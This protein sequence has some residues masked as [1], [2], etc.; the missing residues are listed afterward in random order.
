[1][2]YCELCGAANDVLSLHCHRCGGP[3]QTGVAGVPASV[4][5]AAHQGAGDAGS[6][7]ASEINT[8][9]DLPDW[10]KR[11][12]AQT[13]PQPAGARSQSTLNLPPAEFHVAEVENSGEATA[14]TPQPQPLPPVPTSG[15]ESAVPAWLRD[16]PAGEQSPPT[17]LSAA[18]PQ[19]AQPAVSAPVESRTTVPDADA[20]NT[21]TFIA[22]NDLPDWIRQIAAADAAKAVEEQ[23]LAAEAA[24]KAQVD[25]QNRSVLPGEERGQ[26]TVANPWLSRRDGAGASQ[27]WDAPP[28][29]DQ[30]PS[31][32]EL[33]AAAYQ[34]VTP[35]EAEQ[36]D[37]PVSSKR[38]FALQSVN[39]FSPRVLMIGAGII[40]LL[41]LL[42]VML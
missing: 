38:G 34:E 21:A 39:R 15:L 40:L 7:A 37:P 28:A 6:V 16:Q 4:G 42:L 17:Y 3:L 29:A 12:A 41:V 31:A 1:V 27:A 10:L 23:H 14:P 26:A 19:P 2:H 20:S 32:S 25:S 9:L 5:T 36:M 33:P 35:A 11:A 13:P 24:R 8:S 30:R 22:E 18:Q